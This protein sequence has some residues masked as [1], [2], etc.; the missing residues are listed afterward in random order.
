MNIVIL[1]GNVTTIWDNMPKNMRITIADNYRDKTTF[2]P[3]VCFGN[4]AEWVR[5]NIQKGDHVNVQATVGTYKGRD[6]IERVT[7]IAQRITFEGYRNPRKQSQ[8]QYNT[9]NT[10]NNYNQQRIAMP[11]TTDPQEFVPLEVPQEFIPLEFEQNAA[12]PQNDIRQTSIIDDLLADKDN[13]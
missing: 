6:G 4:N 7:V 1:T 9:Y 13:M 8:S 11:Q 2:V 5:R 10:P 12:Q 3:V